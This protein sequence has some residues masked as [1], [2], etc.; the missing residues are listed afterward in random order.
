MFSKRTLCFIFLVS[1]CQIAFAQSYILDGSRINACSGFFTDS[2]GPNGE[3]ANNQDLSA[4]ICSDN[5]GGSH[6]RL[7]FFDV[8]IEDG[9]T[10]QFFDDV[11]PDPNKLL[12]SNF[13]FI[14][15]F[16]F[17][18]QSSIANP[19]GCITVTFKSNNSRNG[20][21]WNSKIS[22][23]KSCQLFDATIVNTDPIISPADTGWIDICPGDE[24]DFTAAG[25]Y[26]QS[27]SFYNQDDTS[28][29][30]TWDFGDGGTGEGQNIKYKFEEPGGYKVTLQIVDNE[31]CLN[32]NYVLQRVRVAP[33]P[34]FEI[35]GSLKTEIC[36]RDTLGITTSINQVISTDLNTTTNTGSFETG[37][38]RS[39]S[40]ALPDGTGVSYSTPIEFTNFAPGQV[41]ENI[42]DLESICVNMEHSWMRDMNI[43]ISCPNGTEVE[44]HN[45]PGNTGG[46]V[47]LGEPIDFDLSSP[48]PGVGYDY[49]WSM[50][51]TNPTWINYANDNFGIRG[52]GTLPPGDYS[53]YENLRA[54]EGCPLNGNWTITV[55]DWWIQDNGFIFNW[56]INFA[57]HLFPNLE[58]FSPQIV[59]SDWTNNSTFLTETTDELVAVPNNAGN[60]DYIYSVTDDFGCKW[61]TLIHFD[62][63]PQTHPDCYSCSDFGTPLPD[64]TVCE[65]GSIQLD[66]SPSRPT[67]FP[68]SFESFPNE[69]IGA[70]NYPPANAFQAIIDVNY[71][72]PATLEIPTSQ[73]D[74]ICFD[75]E[76][77]IAFDIQVS[78][79][80]PD[81]RSMVLTQNNGDT[82]SY[83]QTCFSPRASQSIT[84]G[85]APF[86]GSFQPQNNDWD[87]LKDA[88]ING[89][90][91]LEVS[92]AA[93]A[94]EFGI[95]NSW[96]IS[97]INEVEFTY[98]WSNPA[99]VSCNDC[100][101]PFV[102]ITE[103][104]TL[105]LETSDNFNCSYTDDVNLD[106][107]TAPAPLI[108]C[109]SFENGQINLDWAD[110][111][112]VDYYEINIDNQGWTRVNNSQYSFGNY[113]HG[114]ISDI[115]IRSFIGGVDCYSLV[116]TESCQ[117]V[118]CEVDT[119][120]TPTNTTCDG[121]PNGSVS[122]TPQNGFGNYSYSIDGI[123]FQN[124]NNFNNLSANNYTAYIQDELGC[125]DT[126]IFNIAS[127]LDFN[128]DV[129]LVKDVNCFGGNDGALIAEITGGTAPFTYQWNDPLAQTSET[130][131][132]LP[133]GNY[134]V[135]VR[136]ASGC[137]HTDDEM[138]NQ[139]DEILINISKEDVKC[140]GEDSGS[141][142]AN[143]TGGVGNYDFTWND[144]QIQT[145]ASATNLIAG[146][147]TVII[148]DENECS[149]SDFIIIN[150]PNL[151]LDINLS[152]IEKG[153][154]GSG[155]NTA[156]AT[157]TGGTGTNYMFSWSNG[158]T[159][160]N[161]SNIL[162]GM[163]TVD[164]ED[165]NGCI[166][167]DSITIEDYER[168]E[169]NYTSFPPTCNSGTDGR[170]G[171]QRVTGGSDQ[172]GTLNFE[173]NT[174][175]ITPLIE[176]LEGGRNYSVIVT[177]AGGCKGDT[178]IFLPDPD[179]LNVLVSS[180]LVNCNGGMDGTATVTGLDDGATIVDYRWDANANDQTNATATGLA[181]G[182]YQVTISD[183]N[184]CPGYE[185]V[186]VD[187]P[188]EI[189]IDEEVIDNNCFGEREGSIDLE[190]TGGTPFDT[191]DD[192][193]INW[194]NNE[195]GD[196]IENIT[197]GVYRVEVT[198]QNGCSEEKEI[199]VTSPDPIDA[200][201]EVIDATC[202]GDRDGQITIETDGG[203]PPFRYSYRDD[204][205]TGSS[206]LIGLTA[207]TYS[208]TITDRYDCIFL[209]D[210]IVGEPPALEV[211]AGPDIIE[212]P[213]GDSAVLIASANNNMG[214]VQYEWS[215]PF[216]GTLSC[217]FCPITTVTPMT[218]TMYMLMGEDENGCIGSDKIEV[219]VLKDRKVFVPTAFTPNNDFLNDRLLV[220]GKDGTT[221]KIFRIFD[222]WGEILFE[223][224]DFKINDPNIG[225]NGMFRSKFVNSG[226]Y[227]WYLEVEFMDGASDV[228]KG[229]TTVI[230]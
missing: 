156:E 186:F 103:P 119:D 53:S 192:Y 88:T 4:V 198:D 169:I 50:D 70:D 170:I 71:Q 108:A 15:G 201:F 57:D 214:N 2:G 182:I 60:V 202:A 16:P 29:E 155:K 225:W 229:H 179:S 106:F 54:L 161:I 19:S 158:F 199:E 72:N 173:W 83:R 223:E 9:D 193:T 20:Q 207:G 51:A 213:L 131:N 96:R 49:C 79:K 226:V 121:A 157:A 128:L 74:F 46:M 61:D 208:V 154:F 178:T 230:R 180:E 139:P 41:L 55:T 85:A 172:A 6:V 203:S 8:D 134:Q 228:Y 196:N 141:A 144:P 167:T 73:I 21:G 75:L 68:V 222:R 164:V 33:P 159:G 10:L 143:V 132:S 217:E 1:T 152:Q 160:Q 90:W 175:D 123:N 77:D 166:S 47:Y 62:V 117:F 120:V 224:K 27:G 125:S 209:D 42:D 165:E 114:D 110:D 138:V 64:T 28:S 133:V 150:E 39:D 34:T 91:V 31:G 81:G 200:T 205:I 80:S 176:N 220:H 227:Y 14:E 40:L 194:S 211:N 65:G 187:E 44:L 112:A 163:Y 185:Q 26:F 184:G 109:E 17:I 122:L 92:D 95:L 101:D 30:F 145:T 218:S 174:S 97:F 191:G 22:C 63:L 38:I 67:K 94:G 102:N 5:R 118:K 100:P 126:V 98:S 137:E 116:N 24:V 93:G 151:A 104:T 3:Y 189:R 142:I 183:E 111:P 78:I 219:R 181:S 204:F 23:V 89:N 56:S 162:S 12:A 136:D 195:T 87:R 59:S 58:T 82:G 36:A 86:T 190:V 171:I 215:A 18:V 11:V 146:T 153:C 206:N 188:F 147:Y 7:E 76:T 177:D 66:A 105:T 210:V 221:I 130:A 37:G 48:R 25:N 129:K 127:P 212:I 135:T 107:F 197:A 32:S 216:N 168:I 140:F 115:Q 113:S 35:D 99:I 149:V 148:K 43:T 69:K 84:T 45:H 124:D 13:E 52:S